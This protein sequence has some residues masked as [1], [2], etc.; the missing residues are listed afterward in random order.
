M[1]VE[2]RHTAIAVGS[3][4]LSVLATPIMVAWMENTAMK[5]AAR[6]CE[7]GQTTVG[8]SLNIAHTRATPIGGEVHTHARLINQ[9]GRMLV[10]EVWAEDEKGEIGRGEHR[11]CIVNREKFMA[12]L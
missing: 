11:R 7:L 4:D 1:L 8:V 12:K 3:G 2:A 9:D 6:A 5:E 10:F